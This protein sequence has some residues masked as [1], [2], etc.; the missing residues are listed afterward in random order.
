MRAS[1]SVQVCCCSYKSSRGSA[2]QVA[3]THLLVLAALLSSLRISHQRRATTAF[4]VA[5]RASERTAKGRVTDR[6]ALVIIS[7]AATANVVIIIDR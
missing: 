7:V 5:N 4:T 3:L 6:L 1:C 2:T